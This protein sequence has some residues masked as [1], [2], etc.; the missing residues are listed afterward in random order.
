MTIYFK[1]QES[2]TIMGKEGEL[3][4]RKIA[5]ALEHNMRDWIT[6]YSADEVVTDQSVPGMVLNL[7]EV[8]AI[9]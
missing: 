8:I 9:R 7:A 6:I 4:K 1:N 2:I 3:V 5:Y